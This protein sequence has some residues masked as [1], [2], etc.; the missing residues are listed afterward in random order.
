LPAKTLAT[1]LRS[2]TSGH[3]SHADVKVVPSI[4]NWNLGHHAPGTPMKLCQ[5]ANPSALATTE[6]RRHYPYLP[7]ADDS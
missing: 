2:V 7:T 5:V 3:F 1:E 4:L 6:K